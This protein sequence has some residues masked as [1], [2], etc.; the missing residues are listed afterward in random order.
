M[1]NNHDPNEYKRTI[2]FEVPAIG[3]SRPALRYRLFPPRF[4][5]KLGNAAPIYRKAFAM[6]GEL[7]EKD[8][9]RYESMQLFIRGEKGRKEWWGEENI[10]EALS[11]EEQ[12]R[13]FEDYREFFSLLDEAA[14]CAECD[15]ELSTED[16]SWH[17]GESD[18][19][20]FFATGAVSGMLEIRTCYAVEQDD[21]ELAI[22]S[23]RTLYAFASHLQ[24][25]PMVIH[26]ILSGTFCRNATS[27]VSKLI[28][29][30][31]SPNLYWALTQIPR[32]MNGYCQA[33]ESGRNYFFSLYPQ[34]KEVDN[35][36][37]DEDHEYWHEFGEKFLVDIQGCM[38]PETFEAMQ[39]DDDDTLSKEE[40]IE[41]ERQRWLEWAKEETLKDNP[42]AFEVFKKM[43]YPADPRTILD[44]L[45][46][47]KQA[48]LDWGYPPE[49]IER[50]CDEHLVA[51]YAVRAHEELFD[52][53]T[54]WDALDYLTFQS[55]SEARQARLF[56]TAESY[57]TKLAHMIA[58]MIGCEA[59]RE[60]FVSAEQ[61][62]DALR[63]IEALRLYAA[64]HGGRLPKKLDKIEDVPVPLDPRTREPFQYKLKKTPEGEMGVLKFN[65]EPLWEYRYELRIMPD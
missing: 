5:C 11:P 6:A 4:A 54:K 45:L 64:S 8:A 15:W 51:I 31:K 65:S 43:I 20:R 62:L 44:E 60:V 26:A 23:V 56:S 13:F 40:A 38:G 63:V 27:C 32:F 14:L 21:I 25:I 18:T 53:I 17:Q 55:S 30:G 2:R 52:E 7:E 12:R 28:A 35:P 49:R 42:D 29:S 57:G 10:P 33:V 36:A 3:E 1:E 37:R 22:R 47:I 39:F 58:N 24:K 9:D 41:Q 19:K 59:Y 48:V 61:E 16:L 50:L 34:L 46:T